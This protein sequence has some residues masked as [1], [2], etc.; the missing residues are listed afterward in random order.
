MEA[1]A[2]VKKYLVVASVDR[3]WCEEM[4]RGRKASVFIS[5]PSQI[6]NQWELKKTMI[7]PKAIV[8]KNV[9]CRNGFIN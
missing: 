1:S 7:V 2:C 8:D 6:K 3:G 4:R 5:K 9:K